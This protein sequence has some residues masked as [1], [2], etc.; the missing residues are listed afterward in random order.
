MINSP[1]LNLHNYDHLIYNKMQEMQKQKMAIR[2]GLTNSCEEKRN[3]KQR[4][5]G[6]I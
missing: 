3:E 6:K 2:G 1:E 5:K 4:R